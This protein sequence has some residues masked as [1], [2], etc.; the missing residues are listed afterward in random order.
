M[1]Y[2]RTFARHL[3]ASA[4]ALI[5]GTGLVGIPDTGARA[6]QWPA[7]SYVLQIDGLAC[8]YCGY[9][10]EKQ[11]SKQEGVKSTD[12]DIEKGVV[13]VSVTLGT[14]LSDSELERIVDDA[15]FTLGGITQRP[16]SR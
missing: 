9:G 7:D 15:G 11:F 8:P 10:V 3:L 13:I 16:R 6:A 12:I 2:A 4:P 14:E 1:Q 5:L